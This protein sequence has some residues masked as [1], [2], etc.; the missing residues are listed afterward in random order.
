[1]LND[2]VSHEVIVEFAEAIEEEL[3][4]GIPNV[5]HLEIITDHKYKI[6]TSGKEDMRPKI[7]QLA[8]EKGWSLLSLQQT[9]RSMENVFQELTK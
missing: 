4:R 2:E 3:L 8:Y 7:S 5:T 1:M 6:V 9:E